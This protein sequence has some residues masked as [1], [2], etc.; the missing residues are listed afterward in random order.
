MIDIEQ[1]AL[2]AIDI[3]IA[4]LPNSKVIDRNVVVDAFLDLRQD[5]LA[6]TLD[7]GATPEL[8]SVEA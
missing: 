4:N 7:S 5:L 2:N 1:L 6:L 8:Q 3:H